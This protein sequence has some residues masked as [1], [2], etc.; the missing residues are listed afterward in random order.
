MSDPVFAELRRKAGEIA[1]GA[2]LPRFYADMATEIGRSER[3]IGE[4]ADVAYAREIIIGRGGVMGH[5]F[6]HAHSVAV[7]AGAI[8]YAERGAD[9]KSDL[10][11]RDALIAGYLHDIRRDERDHPE[12]AA[13]EVEGLF[14]ER[15]AERDLAIVLFAIRNHEAFREHLLV[16]EEDMMLCSDALYDA[17]KFRWGPDNFTDTIWN[18]AESMNV[19]LKSLVDHYERG[20]GGIIQVRDSFRTRTGK[21]YGPDFIDAGLEISRQIY[22]L[23][24]KKLG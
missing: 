20:V 8:I 12:K 22:E 14:K 3:M 7:E 2:R 10:L 17:D 11:V 15:L 19:S 4:W 16:S 5:G 23:C 6:R 9:Q 13:R 21:E 18:M 24:L 1:R